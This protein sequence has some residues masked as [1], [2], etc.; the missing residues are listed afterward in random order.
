MLAKKDKKAYQAKQLKEIGV[1]VR[2]LS[3][4]Y[5]IL[6]H[7]MVLPRSLFRACAHLGFLL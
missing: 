4:S 2:F 7:N 6:S 5:R 1:E 3:E